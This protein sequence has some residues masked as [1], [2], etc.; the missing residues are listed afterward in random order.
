MALSDLQQA[1]VERLLHPIIQRADRPEVRTQL[2]LGYRIDRNA[3]VLFESR[4]RWD[5]PSEWL[6]EPVAKFQYVASI[7]RWRLFCMFRDLKWRG[8]EP[9]PEA[10]SLAELVS[11]VIRDPTGIFWG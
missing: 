4:V 5:D 1:Q 10:G 3:V 6:E 7:S 2:R 9:L 11:E 8:Y